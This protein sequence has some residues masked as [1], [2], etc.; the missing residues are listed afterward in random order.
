MMGGTIRVEST[1]GKGSVFYFTIPSETVEVKNTET[2]V[3][4]ESR[5][6]DNSEVFTIMIAEDDE[7]SIVYLKSILKKINSNLIFATTGE[8]A[9]KNCR[10]YPDIDLV[11]MDIK[12]HVMDG[13]T[14]AKLI[15]E[16]RPELPV[17]AQT[18]YALE[19]EITLF[20]SVFDDYVTKP[21]DAFELE[22]KIKKLLSKKAS[23][24]NQ[25]QSNTSF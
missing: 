10:E 3:E 6:T 8:E 21:I 19:N 4:L 2:S 18:A 7:I 20:G 11:L 17:I 24:K 14:A 5:I 25:R 15:R 13:Y 23:L 9:V 12:L 16:F 1:E 22:N